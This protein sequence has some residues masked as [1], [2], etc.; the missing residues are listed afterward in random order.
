MPAKN[1]RL[2]I[3]LQPSLA[4]QLRKLSELT[5]N[6]QSSIIGDLLE[7]T[8]PVFDRMIQILEAAKQAKDSIRGKLAGDLEQAQNKM[9]DGLGLAM[10][11]LTQFFDLDAEKSKAA[12]CGDRVGGG[13]TSTAARPARGASST[14]STPISNRGVRLDP[15]ATK[16]IAQN[17]LRVRQKTEKSGVKIRGGK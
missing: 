14:K 16:K 1:P 11:G 10:E 12:S 5:G 9:E 17:R 13:G 15:I 4:A 8:G 7:G 6:S 2:T 3:T